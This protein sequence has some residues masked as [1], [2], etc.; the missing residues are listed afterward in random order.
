V[1]RDSVKTVAGLPKI[2]ERVARRTEA[3]PYK[4]WGF[5]EAIAMLGLLAAAQ[6]ADAPYHRAF[7]VA[8]FE[9]WRDARSGRLTFADH[10][11][12]GVPLLLLARDD[13]RWMPAALSLAG[14]FRSFP[15]IAGIPVHRPDLDD[16]ATHIWV[17]CLYTD[18]PFLA[19]LGR[20]SGDSAWYDLACEHALAYVSVLWDEP[21]G[22]FVHGYDAGGGRANAVH[23]GRGNGWALLGLLDLLRVL[24]RGHASWER[25]AAVASRQII[26]MQALQDPSGHWHTV[27]DHPETYLETSVAAMMAYAL[28]DGARLELAAPDAAYAADRALH[29][30]LAAVDAAGALTGVSEATPAGDLETYATRPAGVYPWGQGPLLLALADRLAPGRLWEALV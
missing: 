13:A 11:A 22:L 24:P 23:W 9:R 19:L 2:L 26:E 25:L 21:A 1:D 16:W 28:R 7:V 14:L 20:M 29:A 4:G 15:R 3:H 18:G 8:Q 12:P 6:V 27:L 5:G 10:V 30:A 17:D